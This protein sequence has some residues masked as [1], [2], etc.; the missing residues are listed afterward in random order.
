MQNAVFEKLE[1]YK[2]QILQSMS[3]IKT[4]NKLCLIFPKLLK[5]EE[6]I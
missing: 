6:R 1:K 3:K 2:L 4:S 5:R